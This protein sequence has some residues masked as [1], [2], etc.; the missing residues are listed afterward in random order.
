[1]LLCLPWSASI[2][3]LVMWM[4]FAESSILATYADLMTL[5][6][7]DRFR[8]VDG[9]DALIGVVHKNWLRSA[10]DALFSRRPHPE[11][12]RCVWLRHIESLIYPETFAALISAAIAGMVES[13]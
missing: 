12:C 2:D 8:I 1:V 11:H 7:L 13:A 3:S 9:I 10:A 4:V 6:T 5:V